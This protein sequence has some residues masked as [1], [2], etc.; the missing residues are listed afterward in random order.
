MFIPEGMTV[1]NN[2]VNSFKNDHPK[3]KAKDINFNPKGMEDKLIAALDPSIKIL[4]LRATME[5]Q[6]SEN[7]EMY[8]GGTGHFTEGGHEV[9]AEV[10]SS[11]IFTSFFK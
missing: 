9:T 7:K 1:D 2:L 11:F 6:E 8:K 3:L 4:N 5:K 10:L